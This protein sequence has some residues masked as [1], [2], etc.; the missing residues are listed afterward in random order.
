M[1]ESD[2]RVLPIVL[3][4]CF[5]NTF[6]SPSRFHW[7]TR[8]TMTIFMLMSILSGNL[9]FSVGRSTTPPQNLSTVTWREL[10]FRCRSGIEPKPLVWQTNAL[11]LVILR[12]KVTPEK[13][14]RNQ[15]LFAHWKKTSF[16]RHR[17]NACRLQLLAGSKPP[18]LTGMSRCCWHLGQQKF[19]YHKKKA[20]HEH[21]S[22]LLHANKSKKTLS[23]TDWQVEE[24]ED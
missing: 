13:S 24:T 23:K 5:Y 20:K 17:W 9:I 2:C 12:I 1:N 19:N 10:C 11:P 21:Y 18:W 6:L 7:R 8:Q 16:K 15:L 3:T 22:C 4:F 14:L